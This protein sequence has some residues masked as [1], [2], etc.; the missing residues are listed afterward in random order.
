MSAGVDDFLPYVAPYAI[1]CP[2]M[3]VE[4]FIRQ[5][6]DNFCQDTGVWSEWIDVTTTAD[7]PECLLISIASPAGQIYSVAQVVNSAGQRLRKGVGRTFPDL[8]VP[9][10]Y[11]QNSEEEITFYPTPKEEYAFQVFVFLKP[12]PVTPVI[13]DELFDK[14]QD[15]IV[16]GAVA[17]LLRMPGKTWSDRTSALDFEMDF[18]NG[19]TKAKMDAN[20][21]AQ[22]VYI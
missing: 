4:S 13:P 15:T 22:R 5:A 17:K 12:D 7:T 8:G 19:K 9:I 6:M 11:K 14:Y 16:A 3:L 1:N 21:A 2:T 18:N 10:A 20:A